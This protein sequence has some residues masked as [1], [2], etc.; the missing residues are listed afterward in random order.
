M[1]LCL[2][3]DAER[4]PL[5]REYNPIYHIGENSGISLTDF[6]SG[7]E[8]EKS[9][10]SPS[11]ESFI[12]QKVVSEGN[13]WT[14]VSVTHR[15]DTLSG[16]ANRLLAFIVL[17]LLILLVAIIIMMISVIYQYKPIAK[18]AAEAAGEGEPD[19]R[20]KPIDERA[21]LS[22]TLATLRGDSEQKQK[23]QTAYYEA[24]AASK[25]K[26]AFLSSMSHDIRTPM[27]A[28]IGMT[29]LSLKHKDDPAYVEDCLK[30]VQSSSEYLLDIINNVLDMS[31]IESGRI[32]IK[33]EPVSITVIID[34]VISLMTSGAEAKGQTIETDI[35]GIRQT[36]VLGDSVHIIQ[37][38]VNIVS[39]AVKFTPEGGRI[40]VK[41]IQTD[42]DGEGFVDYVFTFTDTGVGIPPEFIDRVFETFSR[43][44][45]ATGSKTEGNG[46]GMAIAKK[47]T[48]LMNGKIYCESV[49]GKGTTFTVKL[50]MNLANEAEAEIAEPV[51]GRT[52]GADGDSSKTS[53]DLSG[54]H[55]L[56]AEDNLINR[57]IA[58]SIISE[59]GAGTDEAKNGKE[60]VDAFMKSPEG[61]YDIILMDIQMPVMNGYEAT[62]AIRSSGRSDAR[63]VIIYAVTANTFDEDVRNVKAAGMNGHIGKPYDPEKLYKIL[64]REL[65]RQTD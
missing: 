19:G 38:F 33:S 32:P 65:K 64:S 56:L 30:K 25:A 42:C 54:R 47:L 26:S 63:T 2:R 8:S 62:E 49:P 18:L 58:H 39:N 1:T 5:R 9:V 60:A 14:Y 17:V 12:L 24:E 51:N 7:A 50:R 55:I 3:K 45:D 15:S 53:V 43:A 23:Y 46:L 29:A 57:Q 11:G 28:V 61:Y 10:K 6:V 36:A 35:S 41:A 27:N 59:T 13:S 52:H 22:D 20:S 34:S 4:S 37:V 44:D 31:R 21:L 16:L 40:T 48:E